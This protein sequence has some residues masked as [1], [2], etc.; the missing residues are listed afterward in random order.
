[1]ILVTPG[2]RLPD[3]DD[4]AEHA[5]LARE[6]LRLGGSAPIV[7][8]A[9]NE[10]AVSRF[11][12]GRIRFLDIARAVEETMEASSPTAFHAISEVIE[13]DREARARAGEIVDGFR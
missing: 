8:N 13:I 3:V 5:R 7:L 2:I 9:A 11:L 12:A 4:P 6:A 1:M 10:I